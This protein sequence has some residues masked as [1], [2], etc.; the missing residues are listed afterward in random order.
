MRIIEKLNE[1]NNNLHSIRQPLIAFL[2]DS[3]T[4]GCYEL[5][6]KDGKVDTVF[7]SNNNYSTKL[8]EILLTFFPSSSLNIINAGISGDRAEVGLRRLERDVLSY[9]PD[10]VVVCYGLNDATRKEAEYELYLNSLKSIFEKVKETGAEIIFMTPNLWTDKIDDSIT[11]NL[12]YDAVKKVADC[13]KEGWLKKYITSA[14]E[15][16]DKMDIPVCDCYKI[17][18][19]FKRGG[20]DVNLLLSNK[21][22]HPTRDMHYLFAYEL[23][24]TMFN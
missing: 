13:E 1:K 2:G 16:C 7:D 20:V 19:T 17:W 21:A 12:I 22:N 24:K 9:N 10:L 23:V 18:E 5:Y 6:V 15:L 14:K 8:K 3:V 4:Q 11:D